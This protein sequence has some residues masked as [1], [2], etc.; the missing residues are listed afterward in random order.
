MSTGGDRRKWVRR[1]VDLSVRLLFP[2]AGLRNVLE[3]NVRLK[4]IS[5]GGSLMDIGAL[6]NV[7]DFFYIQFGNDKS[8][9]I[10]CYVA[11]RAPG[12][13]RAQFC[14]ELST[15]QV[16]RI[17]AHA[18]SSALIDELFGGETDAAVPAAEAAAMR[19]VFSGD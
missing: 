7:P 11:G 3:A 6:T 10:G 9:M 5:E 12:L 1:S 4:D 8:E 14:K 15:A 13:I 19:A 16:D 17:I 18:N 2:T